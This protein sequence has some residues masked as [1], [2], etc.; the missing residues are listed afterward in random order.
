MS[1]SKHDQYNI[2]LATRQIE[3]NEWSYN[4]KMDTL[5]VFQIMFISLLFV[6]ILMILKASGVVGGPFVWY[7]LMIVF[8]IVVII[9]IN[10]SMYTANRRDDVYWNRRNFSDDNRKP[11]PLGPGASATYINE[12]KGC[13]CT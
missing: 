12:V 10:R 13:Q 6:S 3:I 11:S 4:N 7:S 9:I 2:D 1:W 8:I 5:F